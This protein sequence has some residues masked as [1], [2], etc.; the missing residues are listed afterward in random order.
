VANDFFEPAAA[1]F[2]IARSDLFNLQWRLTEKLGH[3]I[4]LFESER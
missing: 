1:T 2:Q 4:S 3:R